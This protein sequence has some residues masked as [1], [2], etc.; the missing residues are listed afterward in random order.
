MKDVLEQL[1][2]GARLV[3]DRPSRGQSRDM[4]KEEIK[5]YDRN[6]HVFI[7]QG[8]EKEWKGVQVIKP[9][10]KEMLEL[11][12]KFVLNG[13]S[14]KKDQN[15]EKELEGICIPCFIELPKDQPPHIK[16]MWALRRVNQSRSMD[17]VDICNEAG[18]LKGEDLERFGYLIRRSFTSFTNTIKSLEEDYEYHK[19]SEL[20]P[21]PEVVDEYDESD[22]P[23]Y[24]L[25]EEK[26][27]IWSR[28]GG[29]N[30]LYQTMVELIKRKSKD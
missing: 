29:F 11:Y 9:R 23:W 6:E 14:E 3:V 20:G 10:R 7:E 26:E 8:I 18:N 21:C 12:D 13:Y 27:R 15:Y 24:D 22:F 30:V 1:L 17:F 28:M 5:E 4:T 16:L 25:K 19:A 2:N